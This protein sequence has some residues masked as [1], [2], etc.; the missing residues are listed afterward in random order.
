MQATVGVVKQATLPQGTIRY[1]E[2]GSGPALVFV[3]GLLASGLLWRKVVPLLAPRFRCI[4]PDW[5]LGS[6][7]LALDPRADVSPR[8]LARL[9]ADFV[10]ALD[11]REAT[12]VGNDTGGAL[13]Q[14]VAAHHPERVSALVLT[15]CDA[16]DNFPPAAFQPMVWG[17]RVPGFLWVLGQLC[18]LEGVRRLPIAYGWLAKHGLDAEL[19]AAWVRPSAT[20]ADIRRDLRRVL[21]GISSRHTLEAAERLRGFQGPVLLAWSVEDRFFP[22]AHAQRLA[23][24]LPRA[25]VVPIDDAWTFSP[26]DQPER[27]ASAIREFLDAS[28]VEDRAVASGRG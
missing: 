14:M 24:I 15:S 25:T 19:G 13:C 3:H 11:L 20:R 21:G 4:V 1:R 10:A 6:H 22:F 8:G 7:E 17:S 5:P 28:H 23:A 18:R 12:L 27:L 26:E 9:I 2:H 16:F